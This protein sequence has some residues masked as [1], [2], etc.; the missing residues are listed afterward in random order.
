[1]L[2]NHRIRG[3]KEKTIEYYDFNR[4]RLQNTITITGQKENK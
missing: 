3:G 1:M 2:K 4:A